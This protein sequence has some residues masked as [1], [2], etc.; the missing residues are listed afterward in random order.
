MF[1]VS[2]LS[3]LARAMAGRQ[4]RRAV[5]CTTEHGPW[6]TGKV[7]LVWKSLCVQISPNNLFLTSI[8][9]KIGE[10]NSKVLLQT[11]HG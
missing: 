4:T 1:V 2:N 6:E 11:K 3:H 9:V 5:L 7:N 8:P 10:F